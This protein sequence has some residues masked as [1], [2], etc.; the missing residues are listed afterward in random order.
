MWCSVRATPPPWG[1]AVATALPGIAL[2]MLPQ[3][4]SHPLLD[5]LSGSGQVTGEFVPLGHVAHCCKSLFIFSATLSV[6]LDL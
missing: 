1:P 3:K 2:V 6:V 5:E 4:P